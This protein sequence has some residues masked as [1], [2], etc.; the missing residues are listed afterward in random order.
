M[1]VDGLKSRMVP[2]GLQSPYSGACCKTSSMEERPSLERRS[3]DGELVYNGEKSISW[4]GG[5][6]LLL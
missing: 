4:N 2:K 1:Q 3:N 5:G 6:D